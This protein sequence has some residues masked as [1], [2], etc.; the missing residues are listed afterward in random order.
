ML[1]DVA[2][3]NGSRRHA[4]R[5]G[6]HPRTLQTA[7][8]ALYMAGM[9]RCAVWRGQNC[10]TER[11]RREILAQ[12]LLKEGAPNH[13]VASENFQGIDDPT[14]SNTK[15]ARTHRYTSR[16]LIRASPLRTLSLRPQLSVGGVVHVSSRQ[17]LLSATFYEPILC[18]A[19]YYSVN[20]NAAAVFCYSSKS[21]GL[22][23]QSTLQPALTGAVARHSCAGRR[24]FL[25]SS[26]TTRKASGL[27]HPHRLLVFVTSTVLLLLLLLFP[28]TQPLNH[29]TFT[30]R[31]SPPFLDYFQD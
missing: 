15:A 28:V 11:K 7:P 31:K 20:I 29:Y 27:Q 21:P 24:A 17:L 18:G 10:Q 16:P 3:P 2:P 25:P 12:Y 22:I 1:T 9:A 4:T 14:P 23:L 6:I 26:T 19:I 8:L 5:P 13:P 30:I